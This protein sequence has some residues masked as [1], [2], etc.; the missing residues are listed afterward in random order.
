ML[1]DSSFPK[2]MRQCKG[3]ISVVATTLLHHQHLNGDPAIA[4]VL[5]PRHVLHPHGASSADETLPCIRSS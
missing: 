3:Q 2:S 5:E 1:R 4:T